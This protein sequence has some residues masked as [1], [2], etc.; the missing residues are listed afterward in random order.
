MADAWPIHHRARVSRW[1]GVTMSKAMLAPSPTRARQHH[2]SERESLLLLSL[3]GRRLFWRLLGR[4]DR[5]QLVEIFDYER[6]VAGVLDRLYLLQLFIDLLNRLL[7]V[8]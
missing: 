4:H 3:L 2:Q 8:G 7:A 1:A 5:A 6:D